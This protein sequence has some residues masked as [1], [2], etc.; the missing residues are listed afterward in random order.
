MLSTYLS[1]HS[2]EFWMN[3]GNQQQE[4]KKKKTQNHEGFHLQN[5]VHIAHQEFWWVLIGFVVQ[6]LQ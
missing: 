6:P 1:I 5:N 4:E 3:S 2:L